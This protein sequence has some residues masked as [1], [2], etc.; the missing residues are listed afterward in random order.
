MTADGAVPWAAAMAGLLQDEGLRR[1]LGEAARRHV[2]DRYTAQ[3]WS[4]WCRGLLPTQ[5]A[6]AAATGAAPAT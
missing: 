2:L 6:T 1:S 3:A 4:S 5:G